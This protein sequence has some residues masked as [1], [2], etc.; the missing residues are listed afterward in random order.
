M[1]LSGTEDQVSADL[2]NLLFAVPQVATM[3]A[4]TANVSHDDPVE[5]FK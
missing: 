2:M 5:A 1:L 3:T 4:N